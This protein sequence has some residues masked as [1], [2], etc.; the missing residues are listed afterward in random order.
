MDTHPTQNGMT[1]PFETTGC[2]DSFTIIGGGHS[3]SAMK[4]KKKNDQLPCADS[5]RTLDRDPQTRR[6]LNSRWTSRSGCG[7]FLGAR[8]CAGCHRHHRHRRHRHLRRYPFHWRAYACA[9]GPLHR[10]KGEGG[11]GGVTRHAGVEERGWIFTKPMHTCYAVQ[12]TIQ[13]TVV[14][15]TVTD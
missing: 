12:F 1:E 6:H 2:S 10:N 8:A 15:M 4:K 5:G 3:T 14:V 9:W 7:G 11:E 13:P